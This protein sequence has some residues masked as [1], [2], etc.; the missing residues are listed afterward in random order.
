MSDFKPIVDALIKDA[1]FAAYV[2]LIGIVW[3]VLYAL[4]KDWLARRESAQK[5][6]LEQRRFEHQEKLEKLKLDYELKRWREHVTLEFAKRQL[7]ARLAEYPALWA[8]AQVT[9]KHNQGS[10]KMTPEKC[11]QVSDQIELWRYGKGGLLAE[12]ETRDAAIALQAALWNFDG[13]TQAFQRVRDARRLVRQALRADMGLGNNL[14]GAT[15]YETITNRHGLNAE[16]AQLQQALGLRVAAP[17]A[18]T[19]PPN[20]PPNQHA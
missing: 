15:I 3:Q 1:P 11:R 19:Q 13:T 10:T 14:T 18:T 16:L 8:L 2:A 20:Q 12:E 4:S 7:D 6:A 17:A 5:A 9:A